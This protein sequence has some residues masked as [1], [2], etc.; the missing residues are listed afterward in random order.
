MKSSPRVLTLDTL[1][2][3]SGNEVY[4]AWEGRYFMLQSDARGWSTHRGI[5]FWK[6]D[7]IYSHLT[8]IS[9]VFHFAT[10]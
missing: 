5:Q 1:M 7:V 8:S 3:Y 6:H 9:I 2:N 10:A 4:S